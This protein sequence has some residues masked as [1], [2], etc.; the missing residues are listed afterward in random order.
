VLSTEAPFQQW[1]RGQT[2]AMSASQKRG[3]VLFFGRANCVAC[4][5][6]PALANMSFHALGM[7]E[8][9]GP[10]V[11][12]DFN[13]KDPVHLGRAS[14][15][16][17]D[18]DRYRFKTPQLYNLSDDAFLG[19]GSSF[20]SIRDVIEY[21]NEAVRQSTLV[22]AER[23]DP[24][25]VPLELTEDEMDD[26][27]AFLERGLYDADLQRHAPTVLPSGNCFP[28]NDPQSREDLGCEGATARPR[29]PEGFGLVRGR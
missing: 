4:H 27:T 24:L 23:L 15:T 25:F 1:L 19:H 9:E 17:R 12:S 26:L 18:A 14:F 8:L 2:G 29:P 22:P 13:P 28:N 16:Q 6:G 3:A 11:F 20:T 21:K 10:G 7:G 5:S